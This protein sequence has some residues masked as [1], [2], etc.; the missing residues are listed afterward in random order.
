[1]DRTTAI[2][3]TLLGI[4]IIRDATVLIIIVIT[5]MATLTVGIIAR[6]GGIAGMT[7]IDRSVSKPT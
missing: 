7:V 3:L 4:S 6:T 2:I 5:I 1:M